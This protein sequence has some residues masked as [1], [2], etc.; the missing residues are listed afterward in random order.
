M[1]VSREQSFALGGQERGQRLDQVLVARMEGW[2]RTR[3]QELIREGRVRLAGAEIKKPGHLIE[4][5]GE[6]VI[7]LPPEQGSVMP[8]GLEPRILFEDA[9][10][11]ALDKPAGLLSH[12]NSG[13]REG[14]V[15]EWA[16]AR[17]GEL[18]HL[19]EEQRAGLA[20]RL[21][22]DTSGVLLVALTQAAL[23]GLKA[24]F[25]ARAVQKTYLALVQGTTRFDSE[26]IENWIGRDEKSRDRIRVLEEGQGRFSS[27]YYET[28]E[29]FKDF[30]YLA[31]FPKTGRMHQVRVHLASIGFP[32]LGETVYRPSRRHLTPLPPEAPQM[33]RHALH[34]SALDLVHPVSGEALHFDSPLPEDMGAVLDWLRKNRAE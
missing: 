30:S 31:V 4:A 21:D 3:L 13:G 17:W 29:R 12:A 7:A 5:A 10:L 2:S 14:G 32:L 26:W 15:A 9:H 25:Q 28:R 34:A 27:T 16:A 20:H 6:L 24:A 1:E 11:V 22:R 8:A 18:P 33:E 19:D 23:E